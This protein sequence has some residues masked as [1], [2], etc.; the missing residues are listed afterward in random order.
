MY[1]VPIY[2]DKSSNNFAF[3]KIELL[4]KQVYVQEFPTMKNP[5]KTEVQVVFII[6]FLSI[7]ITTMPLVGDILEEKN[8]GMKVKHFYE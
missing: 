1:L 6:I 7:L 5:K 4:K 2:F 3:D 8:S